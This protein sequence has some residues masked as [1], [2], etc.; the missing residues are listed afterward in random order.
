MHQ[1]P[2]SKSSQPVAH[3]DLRSLS[4]AGPRCERARRLSGGASGGSAAGGRWWR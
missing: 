3:A 4:W 2:A 1:R